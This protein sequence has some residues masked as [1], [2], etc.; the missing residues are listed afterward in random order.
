MSSTPTIL[1]ILEDPI[2]RG[3][4][5][6]VRLLVPTDRQLYVDFY[7]NHF[8]R[9]C[10]MYQAIGISR[11]LNHFYR[12]FNTGKRFSAL[13]NS[14]MTFSKAVFEES[15]RRGDYYFDDIIGDRAPVSLL[16]FSEKTGQ[17][18]GVCA[19]RVLDSPP[20]SS[21]ADTRYDAHIPIDTLSI[22]LGAAFLLTNF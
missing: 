9:E 13:E 16:A 22:L 19:S 17:L 5:V 12:R 20:S 10:S 3:E 7:A 14:D 4:R 18:I 6:R 11:T 8:V 21:S 2:V 15:R 1:E